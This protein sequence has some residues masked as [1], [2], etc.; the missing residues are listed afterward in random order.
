VYRSFSQVCQN[1]QFQSWVKVS[2]IFAMHCNESPNDVF[3]CA[4]SVPIATY[5]FGCRKIHRPILEI[6]KSLTDEIYECSNW[7]TEHFNSVLEIRWLQRAQ[8]HLWEYINWNQT[9]ILD[10][11]R[12]FI[13][14][15]G[16]EAPPAQD[17][18]TVVYMHQRGNWSPL[19]KGTQA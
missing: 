5:V 12:P 15:V 19:F 8:F 3:F 4:A 10:S 7:E 2:A 9:F 11:R 1:R 16:S 18:R 14:S 6:Y 13:C 17:R